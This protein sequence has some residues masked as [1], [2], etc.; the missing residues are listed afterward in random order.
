[1]HGTIFNTPL[2]EQEQQ[3]AKARIMAFAEV[4]VNEFLKSISVPK[5]N[6]NEKEDIQR[7]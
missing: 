1:M 3:E 5:E 6:T 4:L 2:T 7:F